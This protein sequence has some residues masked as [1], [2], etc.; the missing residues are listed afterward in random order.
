MNVR[1]PS[2]RNEELI[3]AREAR[4]AALERYAELFEHAPVGY[5]TLG[6]DDTVLEINRAGTELLGAERGELVS[7]RFAL[8]VAAHS[9]LT[10]H[11]LR[12]DALSRMQPVHRE[13]DLL[14]GGTVL[15]PVRVHLTAIRGR[16]PRLL[17]AFE[18]ISDRRAQE[19]E[20]ARSEHALR[21]AGQRKDEFLAALSHELRNPLAPIRTCVQILALAEPGSHDASTAVDI[22]DRSA[23]HLARLVDD[24]L[25][26]TRISSGKI[27]LDRGL[28]EL[29][30]L[31]R[32]TAAEHAPDFAARGVA[33]EV[34]ETGDAWVEGDAARLVQITSNL[35]VNA[36]KFTPEGGRVEVGVAIGSGRVRLSVTDDGIGIAPEVIGS[37]GE[38]FVQAPQGLDRNAGGLGLGLALVKTLAALHGG[39]LAITSPGIGRGARAYVELPGHPP[40]TE[41][42][43]MLPVDIPRRRVLVIEDQADVADSLYLALSLR[44][45]DVQVAT[46]GRQGIQHAMQFRP[47]VVFCDI[48]L[49]DLDG[50]AVARSLR[51]DLSLGDVRLVALTGYVQPS[52]VA[53]A[54]AAGFDHHIGKPARI[55]DIEQVFAT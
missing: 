8:H 55:E 14:R 48:G 47:D 34:K 50:Y 17:L 23:G 12:V 10:F 21:I 25:D 41:P 27:E 16:F 53:R 3:A 51:Q 45:H 4:E 22:I 31:V 44:G 46:T 30:S 2:R 49:P 1:A 33:L 35:L 18:D 37:L 11:A 9:L 19:I 5:A 6:Y 29:G 26:V 52:D 39:H 36:M 24:L 38:P 43:R 13:L 42:A 20:L 54:M 7:R 32:R 28:V 40:P 15:V